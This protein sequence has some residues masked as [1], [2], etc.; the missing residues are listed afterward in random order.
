METYNPRDRSFIK[1]PE[2]KTCITCGQVLPSDIKPMTSHMG[3][4][5]NIISG[6]A[7]VMNNNAEVVNVQGVD[8]YLEGSNAHKAALKKQAEVVTNPATLP[9]VAPP[10]KPVVAPQAPQPNKPAVNLNKPVVA[11][12]APVPTSVQQTPDNVV[13]MEGTPVSNTAGV[14]A[15]VEAATLPSPLK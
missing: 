13:K 1:A 6:R 12:V 14:Q 7:I 4:Y 2:V 15:P 9:P 10:I 11:P 5:I 8:L 3:K